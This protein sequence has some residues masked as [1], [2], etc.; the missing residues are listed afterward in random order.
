MSVKLLIY[1][2]L[3]EKVH[4]IHR[5]T[6]TRL[7]SKLYIFNCFGLAIPYLVVVVLNFV[8]RFGY[9]DDKGTCVVG[10]QNKSLLPLV[11]YDGVVNVSCHPPFRPLMHC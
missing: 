7:Q 3:V 10:M 6:K 2:F 11:V 5:I 8:Y 9:F 4:V 1:F